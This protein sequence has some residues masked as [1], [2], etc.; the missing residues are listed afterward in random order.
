MEPATIL[1]KAEGYNVVGL[2][3]K[4]AGYLKAL[5]GFI[6]GKE[7]KS[8][9]DQFHSGILNPTMIGRMPIKITGNLS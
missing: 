4:V 2:H 8:S 5:L 3:K 1:A 7:N 9:S 6:N